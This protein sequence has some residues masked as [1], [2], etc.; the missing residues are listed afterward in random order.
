CGGP[1]EPE[2][3]CEGERLK[4]CIDTAEKRWIE[5]WVS[6]TRLVRLLSLHLKITSTPQGTCLPC[7][8]VISPTSLH[9]PS[10]ELPCIFLPISETYQLTSTRPQRMGNKQCRPLHHQHLR[11]TQTRPHRQLLNLRRPTPQLRLL[12]SVP[13]PATPPPTSALPTTTPDCRGK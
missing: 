4:L 5:S 9:F 8:M 2:C 7:L 12:R 1:S 10:L 11:A 3:P 13:W 6:N